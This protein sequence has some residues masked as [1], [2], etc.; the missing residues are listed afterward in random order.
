MLVPESAAARD[1]LK[2]AYRIRCALGLHTST[3][4]ARILLAQGLAS[5]RT[6]ATALPYF[7]RCLAL[8]RTLYQADDHPE[9]ASTLTCIAEKKRLSD[10]AG[11]AA[12]AKSHTF[13]R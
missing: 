12:A 13:K 11:A 1:H 10:A 4:G 7:E 9:T 8:Y 2:E 5:V 3:D 6:P